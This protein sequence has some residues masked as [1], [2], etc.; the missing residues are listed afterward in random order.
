[1]KIA[2]FNTRNKATEYY[3]R[4][5]FELFTRIVDA[6]TLAL[7]IAHHEPKQREDGKYWYPCLDG[8]DYTDIE[9]DDVTVSQPVVEPT[10]PTIEPTEE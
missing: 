4:D 2:I 9:L 8:A 1:M 10:E 5:Y 3:N 6:D 7:T